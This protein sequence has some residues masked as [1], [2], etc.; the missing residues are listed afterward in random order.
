MGRND[1]DIQGQGKP[2]CMEMDIIEM[3][4]N[5]Y[6]ASTV[7]TWPNN[8][9]GCDRG[10]CASHMRVSG[11]FHVMAEF[12]PD[13]WMTPVI[14][15]YK[16]EKYNPS[17]SGNCKANVVQNMN[18]KGAQIQSSQWTG[19]VPGG[20]QCPGGGDLGSSSFTISN[21]VVKGTVVQ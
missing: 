9:G 3:N 1:C 17:P 19:W 2:S 14:N 21:V 7:H 18:S 11:K 10:G 13:G 8:N 4:G 12:S 6:A 5:C 20:D 16:N 15:G